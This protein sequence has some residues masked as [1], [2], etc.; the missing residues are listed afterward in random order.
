MIEQ[1]KSSYVFLVDSILHQ[2]I[3][4]LSNITVIKYVISKNLY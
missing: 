4:S 2:Q 3:E 1:L